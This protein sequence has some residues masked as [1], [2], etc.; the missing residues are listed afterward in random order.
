MKNLKRCTGSAAR[1]PSAADRSDAAAGRVRRDRLPRRG[2]GLGGD[3][4][5]CG[6][7]GRRPSASPRPTACAWACKRQPPATKPLS[8]AAWT[9][10]AAYLA[11]S[12]PTAVNL[13]WA[14]DRMKAA[15]AGLRGQ[16]PGEIA[17]ALLAE[18]QAIHEE[19]R[20]MCRAIGRHGAETAVRR[21][22]RA[23][24]LQRRRA[25]HGRLRHRL[26]GVLRRGRGGQTA[27]RLRRRDPAALAGRAADRLG[28]AA[29]R[30][31]RDADL[32]QHGGP[33]DA[34]GPGPGGGHRGRSHR[35]QRRHGQ[36]D[37]HLRRGRVGRRPQNPLLRRR[38]RQHLRP[39]DWRAEQR[40]PSSS[41]TPARSPTASAGRRR[42]RA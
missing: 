38:A 42:P 9:E 2:G 29:A 26:G 32:R 34:R 30:D 27:A 12:R 35:R 39:V 20:Q 5:R 11:T 13:F 19:D 7:A 36:Q 28:T 31:R 16:P 8:S 3:S 17:A 24:P 22:G 33:G 10:T 40:F 15:A 18:A 23:H 6:S 1:R 4:R 21:A 14:L 25:G 37:R 41:A